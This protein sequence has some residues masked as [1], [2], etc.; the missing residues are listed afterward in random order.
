VLSKRRAQ[1]KTRPLSHAATGPSPT[2]NI[3]NPLFPSKQKLALS[4]LPDGVRASQPDDGSLHALDTLRFDSG[5]GGAGTYAAVTGPDQRVNG[6]WGQLYD[7]GTAAA[8]GHLV[9]PGGGEAAYE[10][11]DTG[12][13]ANATEGNDRS[14]AIKKLEQPWTPT[15]DLVE[16]PDDTGRA[17]AGSATDLTSLA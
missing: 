2:F 9:V 14:A 1:D 15:Y 8:I 12:N 13:A 4:P 5:S 3:E 17:H 11:D 10:Y 16:K 6:E 7:T